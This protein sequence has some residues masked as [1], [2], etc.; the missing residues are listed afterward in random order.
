MRALRRFGAILL[1]GLFIPLASAAG[2]GAPGG[3]SS[4]YTFGSGA[5]G[6]FGQHSGSALAP[7]GPSYY[8]G[9]PPNQPPGNFRRQNHNGNLRI[10]PPPSIRY[11]RRMRQL[12]DIVVHY[13]LRRWGRTFLKAVARRAHNRNGVS[14]DRRRSS[15]AAAKSKPLSV[16]KAGD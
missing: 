4:I 15:A 10:D 6:S 11:E 16:P 2:L 14:R 3:Q 13:D 9:P 12:Y 5:Q 1:A 8:R 7:P